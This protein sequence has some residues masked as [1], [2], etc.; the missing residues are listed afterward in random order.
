MSTTSVPRPPARPLAVVT[1]ASSGI[2]CA[3]ADRLAGRGYDLLLVARREARLREVAASLQAVHGTA[4]TPY[5]ADLARHDDRAR[6]VAAVLAHRAHLE[7]LVNNAGFGIH[8]WFHESELARELEL[9]E[10]NCAAAV[11]LTRGLLPA[12]LERGRGFVL[13]VSSVA[14]FAPGP[15]M[16]L[17]YASKAFVTSFSE[18]L[19]EE[20]RGTGISVTALCP[21]PVDTGFQGVA[22]ITAGAPRSGARLMPVSR[23]ADAGIDAL[24]SARRVVVPGVAN[25]VAAILARFAPRRW[26][27]RSVRAI[28][29]RRRRGRAAAD[30]RA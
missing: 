21:G 5:V 8:G 19:W 18:A 28:Q 2:G 20:Y 17:Y 12:M 9:L 4:C 25:R 7:V 3:L 15:L 6:L 22:G 13:N 14:G 26:T 10:V 1:G 23:V 16:A 24:F 29:E 27:L 30:P 11:H